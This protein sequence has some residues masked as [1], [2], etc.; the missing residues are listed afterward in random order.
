[1][2]EIIL[3][4]FDK[5]KKA[6]SGYASFDYDE[7][8]Y[9]LSDLVKL[10]ICVNEEEVEE[11]NKIFKPKF[12]NTAFLAI[13]PR[14]QVRANRIEPNR[15][16][17]FGIK[18]NRTNLLIELKANLTYFSE[19]KSNRTNL[20]ELKHLSPQNDRKKCCIYY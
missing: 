9:E 20:S 8:S 7:I 11:V 12:I 14:T 1:M 15:T 19:L 10:S 3:D 17:R 16:I 18:A 6:T 4:F 2:N 5:L 13:V